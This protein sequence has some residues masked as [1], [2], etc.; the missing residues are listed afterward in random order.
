MLLLSKS[1][2]TAGDLELSWGASCAASA[3]DYAIDEGQLGL[4]YSHAPRTCSS[5]HALAMTI[6]PAGGDRYYVIAPIVEEFT[7]SLGT[8]VGG[9][10]R[11]DGDPSCTAHRALAPCP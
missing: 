1:G 8:G 6:T 9:A 11:P 4:W 3:P 10:E 7:G 2:Q 5:G